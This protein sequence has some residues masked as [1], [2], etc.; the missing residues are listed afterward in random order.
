MSRSTNFTSRE[1]EM[2]LDELE[3]NREL[4]SGE[5]SKRFP[6]KKE[7][8]KLWELLALKLSSV[9]MGITR[10]AHQ[11]RNKWNDLKYRTKQKRNKIRENMN[12][13]GGGS[14][15][16]DDHNEIELWIIGLIGMR[17]MEGITPRKS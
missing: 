6:T 15:K 1:I 4:I 12:A 17:C 11:V 10:M 16:D 3:E 14:C 5:F 7:H 9:N 8:N 13:T 2:I